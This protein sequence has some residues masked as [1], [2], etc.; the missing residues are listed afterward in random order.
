[1]PALHCRN[2]LTGRGIDSVEVRVSRIDGR[3]LFAA[4]SL[5][6]RRKLGEISG[7]LVT[8]PH[9]RTAVVKSPKIYLIELSRRYALDCSQGN[10][11]KYLNHSC[12]PNCYLRVFRRRVEVYTLHRI[13]AGTELTVDYGVTP[14]KQGM[15]CR[16]GAALCRQIL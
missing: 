6:G 10:A 2:S 15:K 3:G 7:S 8:L 9:A 1:M 11:F 16:C 12:A 4:L 5:P 13:K 14:H